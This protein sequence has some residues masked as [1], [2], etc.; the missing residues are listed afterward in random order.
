MHDEDR[1]GEVPQ[2]LVRPWRH[3]RMRGHGVAAVYRAL[4]RL[5]A[6]GAL[7][8]NRSVRAT[9][10]EGAVRVAAERLATVEVALMVTLGLSGKG[11]SALRMVQAVSTVYVATEVVGA[12]LPRERPFRLEAITGLAEHKPGRSFPSRHV[13]S[14]LAMAAIANREHP[15]LGQLMALVAWAL[16]VSRVAAGLHYPSDVLAGAVLGRVVGALFSPSAS[17]TRSSPSN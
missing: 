12:L 8:L 10:F 13:A 16:G 11:Q 17:R 15:R 7:R 9:P 4:T 6:E 2:G 5:D 1:N 3:W 14:G